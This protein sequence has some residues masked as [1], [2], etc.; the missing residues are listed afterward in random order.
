MEEQIMLKC[1]VDGVTYMMNATT[2][3]D[4]RYFQELA[5]DSTVY[6]VCGD[7]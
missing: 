4:M 6:F 7:E 5:K 2:I 1:T 3:E